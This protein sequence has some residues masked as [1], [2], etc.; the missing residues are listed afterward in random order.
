MN[1]RAQKNAEQI[2][3]GVP[4]YPGVGWIEDTATGEV[5]NVV[6]EAFCADQGAVLIVDLAIGMPGIGLLDDRCR[7]RIELRLPSF[8][9]QRARK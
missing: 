7:T 6:Q 1:T 8:H 4:Q 5:D 2:A 9:S 3:A